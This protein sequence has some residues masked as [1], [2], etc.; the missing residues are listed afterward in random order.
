MDNYENISFVLVMDALLNQVAYFTVYEVFR[1]L[2]HYEVFQHLH[3]TVSVSK[4]VGIT[5]SSLLML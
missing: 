3:I 4:L 2:F 5:T 1:Q